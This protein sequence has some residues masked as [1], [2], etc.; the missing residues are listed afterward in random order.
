MAREHA[1][2]VCTWAPKRARHVGTWAPKHERHVGT[3]ARKARNLSD[4]LQIYNQWQN[5]LP[6]LRKS[7]KI[8]QEQKTLVSAF[9]LSF[10]PYCQKLIFGRDTSLFLILNLNL[11]DDSWCKVYDTRYKIS[12]YLWRIKLSR[13]HTI[14]QRYYVTDCRLN[15]WRIKLSRK[16]S[17][18]QRYYVTDCNLNKLLALISTIR[19]FNSNYRNIKKSSRRIT[20]QIFPYPFFKG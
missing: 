4:S 9:C 2:H 19:F 12:F 10:D 14:L 11:M 20:Q 17:I 13:K 1:K 15:L 16:H 8:R 5:I 3:W 7:T 18:L 6:K